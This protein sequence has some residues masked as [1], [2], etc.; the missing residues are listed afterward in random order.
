MKKL[1]ERSYYQSKHWKQLVDKYIN[2]RETVCEICGTNRFIYS[3]RDPKKLLRKVVFTLHH[4]H[5]HT[6]GRERRE[7]L[8]I[9]CRSCHTESHRLLRRK[10]RTPY[11][12]RMKELI[13]EYF[14]YEDPKE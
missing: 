9:L 11:I 10:S 4:I 7:D 1:P 6:V 14:H 2:C 13:R 3:K 8:Q 12:I 5:Y